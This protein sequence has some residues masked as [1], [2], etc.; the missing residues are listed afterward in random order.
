[1]IDASSSIGG[2]DYQAPPLPPKLAAEVGNELPLYQYDQAVALVSLHSHDT[3]RVCGLSSDTDL[4]SLHAA[5]AASWPRGI[6]RVKEY[7]DAESPTPGVRMVKY[8]L[9]GM[10]WLAQGPDAVLARRLVA[11]IFR[12]LLAL[13]WRLA[14][15]S[16]TS[17]REHDKDAWILLRSAPY[18]V[19]DP[20]HVFAISFN[21]Y[22]RLRVIDAPDDVPVLV[23][24]VLDRVWTKGVAQELNY[25]GAL[26]YKLNGKPWFPLGTQE[27][28]ASRWMVAQLLAH[29]KNYGYTV[30]A[31][32]DMRYNTNSDDESDIDSWIVVKDL[33]PTYGAY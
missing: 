30:Y 13:G 23:R 17:K 33:P 10:P 31:S 29:L 3:L 5:I 20:R 16:D 1:M 4:S 25:Q 21:R 14:L 18:A 22:D 11:A 15:T 7:T 32:I 9:N 2:H 8:K 6:D 28:M 27:A 24:S 12:T 26:E 19:P